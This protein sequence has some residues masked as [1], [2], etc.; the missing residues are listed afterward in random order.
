MQV[1]PERAHVVDA[2]HLPERL[3]DVQIGMRASLDPASVPEEGGCERQRGGLSPDSGSR[4][5]IGV[6]RRIR[7]R[8]G[9]EPL[10]LQLLRH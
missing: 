9:E 8:G 4:Q 10:R 7:E 2:D 3:E 1:V 6:C 5:E